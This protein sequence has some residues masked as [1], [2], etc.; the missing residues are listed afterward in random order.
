MG[1]M[2][3]DQARRALNIKGVY[4]SLA[5][6]LEVPPQLAT[7]VE[8][9]CGNQAFQVGARGPDGGLGA[10]FSTLAQT[11]AYQPRPCLPE[12]AS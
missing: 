2:A 12:A 8:V 9:V 10:R 11:L 4:G 6:L 1:I 5:D 3:M 7:A